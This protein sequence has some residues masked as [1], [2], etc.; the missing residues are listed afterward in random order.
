MIR[1]WLASAAIAGALAAP[2][3][4]SAN[5]YVFDVTT[6]SGTVVDLNIA[7]GVA[8]SVL[9]P[10][11]DITK[12]TGTVGGVSVSSYTGTWGPNGDQVSDGLYLDPFLN[13]V[14]HIDSNGT[15]VFTVQNPPGSGG[16]QFRDRQYL[17]CRH[18]Q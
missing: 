13:H 1:T 3:V 8:D 17:L 4:A 10:G 15:N 11:Y 7:T 5:T 14:A 2:G 6:T 9:T 12:V 16:D 18:W